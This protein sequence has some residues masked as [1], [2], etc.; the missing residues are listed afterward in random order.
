MK[1]PCSNQSASIIPPAHAGLYLN[2]GEFVDFLV[3]LTTIDIAD[4]D[5]TPKSE[6]YGDHFIEEIEVEDG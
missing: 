5:G 4:D 6:Q 3:G 1:K 2:L